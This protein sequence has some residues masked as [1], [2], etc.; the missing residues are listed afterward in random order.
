MNGSSSFMFRYPN[1]TRFKQM[2]RAGSADSV[3][4]PQEFM[5]YGIHSA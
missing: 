2:K 4:I 1:A 3:Q 5:L